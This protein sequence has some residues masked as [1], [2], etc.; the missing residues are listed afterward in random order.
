ME[1]RNGLPQD[2]NANLF[3]LAH[4]QFVSYSSMDDFWRS[5]GIDPYSL[6]NSNSNEK[7]WKLKYE[8]TTTGHIYS[9]YVQH[10]PATG[11]ISI[12]RGTY[13]ADLQKLLCQ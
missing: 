4:Y 13:P 7:C 11:R 5:M 3:Q 6:G 12:K 1:S 9:F 10:N 8:D 2:F